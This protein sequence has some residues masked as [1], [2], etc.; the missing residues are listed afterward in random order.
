LLHVAFAAA[1]ALR[2]GNTLDQVEVC[3]KQASYAGLWEL[4]GGAG[5][6]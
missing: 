1:N 5:G 2:I 6:R 3:G 4:L